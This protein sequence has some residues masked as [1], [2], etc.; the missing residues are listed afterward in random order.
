MTARGPG[1]ASDVTA[2]V[3]DVLADPGHAEHSLPVLLSALD[4]SDRETR[5]Q[6]SLG[7]CLVA[8]AAPVTVDPLTWRLVDRLAEDGENLETRHALAYLRKRYPDRV[9]ETLLRIADAA[10]ER[11]ERRRHEAISRSFARSDYYGQSD[12][13]RDVGNTRVPG[14]GSGDPRSLYREEGETIGGAPADASERTDAEIIEAVLDRD[15][16]DE[17]E[18]AATRVD[19]IE[20]LEQA[21]AGIGLDR[22]VEESRFDE[23]QL[24]APPRDGRYTTDYRTRAAID[25][26]ETG[27]ALR[28]FSE[29]DTGGDAFVDDVTAAL[30]AWAAVDDH[31]LVATLY[32]WGERPQLWLATPFVDETLYEQVALAVDDGIW[33]ALSLAETVAHVHGRGVVHSGIDPY[34]VVYTGTTMDDR[35]APMLTN[36]G[37]LDAIRTHVEPSEYLD[38]RYA[39]PEYFDRKYGRVDHATDV[40]HLGA[41][42][43]HLVTGRAPFTGT[44][45]EV[46][47]GVLSHRPQA[48]TEVAP[49]APAWVDDVVTKAMAKQKLTRYESATQFVADLRRE[50]GEDT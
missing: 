45:E 9:R 44:Y 42:L 40:Y 10:A 7:L 16:E 29:P 26:Q 33:H 2:V 17:R 14:D 21:A 43:Y 50:L 6:A 18:E 3:S 37:L 47:E 48:P 46:R 20:R 35:P 13:N 34:N 36:V 28:T 49:D 24:V 11:E 5:L 22:I 4:D 38:P 30:D 15:D 23:L 41:I 32:D 19:R 8:N 12:T 31:D 1:E 25:G 27:I 39:A